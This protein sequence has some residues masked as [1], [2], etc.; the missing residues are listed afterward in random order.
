MEHISKTLPPTYT[1]THS[2]K[3]MIILKKD[4]FVKDPDAARF[5]AKYGE[6]LDFNKDSTFIKFKDHLLISVHLSSKKIKAEQLENLKQTLI[7]LAKE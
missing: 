4:L 6:T 3:S 5:Q 2:S 1:Y 7:A